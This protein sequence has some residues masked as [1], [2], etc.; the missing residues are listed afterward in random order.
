MIHTFGCIWK[1]IINDNIRLYTPD[2]WNKFI[3]NASTVARG[4]VI[5]NGSFFPVQIKIKRNKTICTYL[6][7]PDGVAGTLIKIS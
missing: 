1:D 4:R 5:I 2:R 3:L 7:R 6:P